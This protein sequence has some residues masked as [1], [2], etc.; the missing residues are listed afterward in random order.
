MRRSDSPFHPD[1]EMP[2]MA[3][4][5]P[6]LVAAVAYRN[7]T[8]AGRVRHPR[9]KGFTEDP[10][11]SVTWEQEGPFLPPVGGARRR[12]EGGGRA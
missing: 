11:E 8:T 9:F 1:P 3:A 5:E 10:P 7:W 4:V 2:A 6:V 12:R